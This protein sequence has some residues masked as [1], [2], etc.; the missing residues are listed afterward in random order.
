MSAF[1]NKVINSLKSDPDLKTVPLVKMTVDSAEKSIALNEKE[2]NV[3]Q[4]LKRDLMAI[5]GQ[6]KNPKID[7]LLEQ[8]SKK[9]ETTDSLYLSLTQAIDLSKSLVNIK[10]ANAYSEPMVKSLVE[11]FEN[12]IQ[13]GFPE[14]LGGPD[15]VASFSRYSYDEAVDSEIKRVNKYLAKNESKLEMMRA[16]YQ[17]ESVNSPVYESLIAELKEATVHESYSADVLKIKYGTSI[18]ALMPLINN[19]RIIESKNTGVFTLGEGHADTKI[20]NLIAPATVDS[21]GLLVYADGRFLSIREAKGLTGQESKIHLDENIKVSDLSPEYV[22]QAHPSF[23]QV[24]ES[25]AAF[26]FVKREDG[27]GLKSTGIRSATFSLKINENKNLSLYINDSL[28]SDPKQINVSES[29]TFENRGIKE[30]VTNLLENSGMLCNL[31]FV[32]EISNDRLLKESMVFKINETFLICEKI[33]AAERQWRTVDEYQLYEFFAKNFQYDVRPIFKTKIDATTNTLKKIEESKQNMLLDIQKLEGAV[34]KL[35]QA[36][37]SNG[38]D[39]QEVSKLEAI[40]ENLESK[41]SELKKS[42]IELEL[43]KKNKSY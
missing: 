25:F 28:V 33:N 10:K 36:C 9:E 34:A 17:L 7:S 24:C 14:F 27:L 23:Y 6:L 38:L 41:I 19:L 4:N 20:A 11:S 2:Q 22:K 12:A 32:K 8:F 43:I 42:Y 29:L 1:V 16:I 15:F 18:P 37:E 39:T 35:N 40:K 31:E 26:G 5:N 3:Y 30:R 13:V 21:N